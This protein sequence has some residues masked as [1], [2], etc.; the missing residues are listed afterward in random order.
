MSESLWGIDAEYAE[1]ELKRDMDDHGGHDDTVDP[2]SGKSPS[3]AFRNIVVAHPDKEFEA[4]GPQF[5]G[6]HCLDRYPLDVCPFPG[7]CLPALNDESAQKPCAVW[8]EGRPASLQRYLAND[9]LKLN[10]TFRE[11]PWDWDVPGRWIG[12]LWHPYGGVMEPKHKYHF[13]TP[14]ELHQCFRG[15]RIVFQGDSIIRQMFSRLVQYLRLQPT[16]CEKVFSWSTASYQ[17]FTDGHDKF[18]PD[19]KDRKCTFPDDALYTIMYDWHEP[20]DEF[21]NVA[22]FVEMQADAVVHAI[23]YWIGSDV[24]LV[25]SREALDKLFNEGAWK[26]QFSWHLSPEKTVDWYDQYDWRNANMRKF[27]NDWKSKGRKGLNLIP[28]DRLV[29][30]DN[31]RRI[32]RD[33]R[34]VDSEYDDVHF[35]C[36]FI[37]TD[38]YKPIEPGLQNLKAPMDFDARDVVNLNAIQVWANSICAAGE[39]SD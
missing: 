6:T 3:N 31:G 19:C 11:E 37:N 10:S 5:H 7:L 21:K 25:Q 30:T 1:K 32:I 34:P 28:M 39:D 12:D 18:N 36:D 27:F 38:L 23:T 35:M 13:F 4:L 20:Q 8:G 33:R 15:K 9:G 17:V 24:D 14:E 16:M 22:R 2:R 29:R 26:G